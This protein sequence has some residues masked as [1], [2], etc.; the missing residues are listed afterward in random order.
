MTPFQKGIWKVG[1]RDFTAEKLADSIS[2]AIKVKVN[3]HK[4]S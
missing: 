3:G 1:G 2:Q 4:P